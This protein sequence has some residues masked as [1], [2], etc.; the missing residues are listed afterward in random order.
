MSLAGLPQH[1]QGCLIVALRVWCLRYLHLQISTADGEVH[2]KS[3][4]IIAAFAE[5]HHLLPS[6]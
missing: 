4:T 6:D 5:A 3:A 1:G 2:G